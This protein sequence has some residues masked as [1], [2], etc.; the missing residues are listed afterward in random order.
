MET[1]LKQESPAVF[2]NASWQRMWS[3][4][5]LT[6]LKV[7]S[8]TFNQNENGTFGQSLLM[9]RRFV[10]AGTRFVQVNWP[11]VANSDRHSWDVHKDLQQRMREDA[12]PRFD[13]GFATLVEDLDERGLL[14]DTLVVCVGEFGRSPRKG[15]STSG[16]DNDA[17]GRDHWPYCFTAVVAGAGVRRGH[18]H[19][20]SD[21]TGT[22]FTFV[23]ADD[24]DAVRALENRLG[25]AI[26]RRRL[27]HH[28]DAPADLGEVARQIETED[29][30]LAV[31]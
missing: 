5:H 8:R 1:A 7:M 19:G 6:E 30:D 4:N 15:L 11:K 20:R 14:A 9:A 28:A 21:E 31:S 13:P 27:E 22:A 2:G 24:A 23:T 17:D 29:R 25:S 10:E 16:N 12:A 18:V 26:E 3:A